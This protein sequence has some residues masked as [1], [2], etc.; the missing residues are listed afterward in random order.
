M[1]NFHHRLAGLGLALSLLA[2]PTLAQDAAPAANLHEDCVSAYDPSVDYFPDKISLTHAENF[3]VAYFNHYK[4]VSVQDAYDG[5]PSFDYVLVQCGTPAPD[6]AD[7]PVGTQ[8]IEVPAR[9]M[10]AL[11]TTQLPH[12][13][14]LGLLD[15][16]IGLDSFLYVNSPSVRQMI[17]A[18]QLIEVGFGSDINL[19]VTLEAE[20]DLVMASGFN[21]ATDAHPKLIEA[22]IFTALNAEWRE[23]TPLGRAEWLK[24]TALFFNAEAEAEEAYAAIVQAYEEARALVADVPQDERPVVLWNSFSPY[25]EAWIIPGAQ[26]FIGQLIADAGGSIALGEEATQNSA[27][28]S[29]EAIYSDALEADVWVTNAFMVNT[30]ADLLAQD[31][32]YADFS[33]IGTGRVWNDTLR[34]NENG[35]N[36]FW[37]SGVTN[38]HLILRDLVAIFY[39]ERLPN[40]EFRF[41]KPLN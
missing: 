20:P 1:L 21:P 8:F 7:F 3:S 40:H 23:A 39:P 2:W 12:L 32:R 26:T 24:Y 11:S 25:S 41:Y 36:D 34:V 4:V 16:L 31:A 5:A 33:A 22:N 19:E 9:R 17:A 28:L 29:F 35:G 13:E 10:I 30:L 38:P 27:S 15:R 37:E 6:A 18:D 14:A